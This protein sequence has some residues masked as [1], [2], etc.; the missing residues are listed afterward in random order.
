MLHVGEGKS[1][2]PQAIVGSPLRAY[3]IRRTKDGLGRE[4]QTGV[5]G[6]CTMHTQTRRALMRGGIPAHT[7]SEHRAVSLYR[8]DQMQERTPSV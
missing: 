8:S 1:I 6:V 3:K 4:G 5:Y 7:A 2:F